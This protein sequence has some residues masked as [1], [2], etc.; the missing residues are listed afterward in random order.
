M[1]AS[2]S[3]RLRRTAETASRRKAVV[4]EKR[5]A[6]TV[7]MGG[8]EARQISEAA[9]SP[10]KAC[11]VA[12][13][14]FTDGIGRVSLARTLPSGLVGGSFFLVDAWPWS[15]RPPKR[16]AVRWFRRSTARRY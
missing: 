8:R 16:V 6:D 2:Q 4:A 11:V 3:Q 14:L 15:R 13:R 1:A 9:R 5:K 12:D 7:M 10:I